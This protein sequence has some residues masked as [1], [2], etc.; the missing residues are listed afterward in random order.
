MVVLEGE[1]PPD[2][3]TEGMEIVAKPKSVAEFGITHELTHGEKK[4]T[5]TPITGYSHGANVNHSSLSAPK[6]VGHNDTITGTAHV[7]GR[8]PVIYHETKDCDVALHHKNLIGDTD[9][10]KITKFNGEEALT[11][12]DSVT[13]RGSHHVTKDEFRDTTAT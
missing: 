6:K 9:D 3:A 10:R 2:R 13:G 8:V 11:L 5:K 12:E 1:A 4:S 7:G